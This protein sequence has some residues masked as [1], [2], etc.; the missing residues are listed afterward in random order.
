MAAVIELD[1]KRRARASLARK[2]LAHAELAK[3]IKFNR[4]SERTMQ[5][6]MIDWYGARD[7]RYLRT[8]E[9]ERL[10]E[11]LRCSNG[12]YEREDDIDRALRQRRA[13]IDRASASNR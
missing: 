1:A 2:K 9:A 10:L 3:F 13:E 7:Y 8:H 4:I 11:I 12:E 6:I 5:R